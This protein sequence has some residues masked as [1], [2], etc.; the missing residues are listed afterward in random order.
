[1]S[2]ALCMDQSQSRNR[3][4]GSVQALKERPQ[5]LPYRI[6]VQV[7]VLSRPPI[8][9]NLLPCT[10]AALYALLVDVVMLAAERLPIRAV[11]EQRHVALVR[12]DVIDGECRRHPALLLTHPAERMLALESR[13]SL[14]PLMGIATLARAASPLIVFAVADA[15]V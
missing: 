2:L 12:D 9:T 4:A 10:T 6:E 7:D 13:S 14:V 5:P 15:L 1:M 11:P 3:P 8:L